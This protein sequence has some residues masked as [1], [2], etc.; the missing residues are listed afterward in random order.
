MRP[1]EGP[2]SIDVPVRAFS[3]DSGASGPELRRAVAVEAPVQIVIGGAPFAVMMAT[4]KNLED[5]AYGFLL[6]EQIADRVSDIRGVEVEQIEDGWKLKIAISGERLQAH[7]ARGRAMSGRT[8]CGL[9]GIEDFSQM[10]SPRPPLQ[11][12][13]PIA[14]DAIRAALTELEAQQ[15]LNHATRAVHAAAWCGREGA[16][17]LVREDVGRHN[18]LDKTIGALARASVAPDSGFFIITSRCSFEM[19]AKVAIFG[20]G[21]LVSVSAPTSL[22]LERAQRFGVRVIAVARRDQALCFD[23]GKDES[24][25]GMAA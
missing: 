24:S 8:G 7:L 9:C 12:Q 15:P 17:V 14:P 1:S 19:V 10:P 4:P 20:A 13:A 18:A 16:I 23:E 5:F 25:G 3:Y 22:A 2:G 6:T 21:T 11:T